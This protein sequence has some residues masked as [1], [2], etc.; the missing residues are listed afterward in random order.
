MDLEESTGSLDVAL[1][2]CV[3][4]F[5]DYHIVNYHYPT[6]EEGTIRKRRAID[7][8]QTPHF[9]WFSATIII[10]AIM[11]YLGEKKTG[12]IPANG[13]KLYGDW[14]AFWKFGVAGIIFNIIVLMIFLT[15]RLFYRRTSG[16]K[17]SSIYYAFSQKLNSY[18]IFLLCTYALI[19]SIGLLW[20]SLTD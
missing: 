6:H 16:I 1:Y 7:I 12:G 10:S 11:I 14:Y 13:F 3:G 2:L 20:W 17:D 15:L 5:L 8:T 4:V 18:Y 19:V 9:S